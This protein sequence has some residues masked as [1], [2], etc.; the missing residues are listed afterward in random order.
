MSGDAGED[1][2]PEERRGIG[3]SAQGRKID[4]SFWPIRPSGASGVP[5]TRLFSLDPWAIIRQAI[6]SECPPPRRA[7]ALACLAQ[8]SAFFEVGTGRGIEAARPLALYYSYLN[9]MKAY[10]LTRGGVTT[11]DRSL[12]GLWEDHSAG[13]G[14]EH[15]VLSTVKPGRPYP[16]DLKVFEQIA[17][18][19][20][21]QTA[22]L[23]ER[24]RLASV[25]PQILSGHRLWA[26]AAHETERFFIIRNIAFR[27][28]PTTGDVWLRIDMLREDLSRFGI[29]PDEMLTRAGLAG[30]FRQ[31]RCNRGKRIR[32]EQISS[33]PCVGGNPLP[34][35]Q[36]LITE[37]R[38]SL[39]MTVTVIPPYRRYYLYLSPPG[40]L[41]QRLPQLLSMYAVTYW[42]G[43]ITRY[44]PHHFD[45]LLSG[46][47]GPRIRD[48][49]TGQPLQF[50]YLMASEIAQRDVARPSI[51]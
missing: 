3:L 25:V 8:A 44:R 30:M 39:W 20:P 36:H 18:I 29:E 27:H 24:Y 28:D 7:E 40:E 23:E 9:L 33:R 14:V 43:S 10:C 42:L 41:S 15:A 21:G 11:F 26:E 32:F 2:L 19:L 51:L 49:V 6:E 50:L 45:D 31:V 34:E 46:D 38:P 16:N 12:H 17:T 13:H 47:Y 1:A 22:A 5:S 35:L 37:L 4:V 48:F